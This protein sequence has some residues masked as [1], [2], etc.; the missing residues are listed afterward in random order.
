MLFQGTNI[1]CIRG[2]S[3]DWNGRG[4]KILLKT[5]EGQD[6]SINSSSKIIQV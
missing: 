4:A 2:K 6:E 5:D 3:R 1:F